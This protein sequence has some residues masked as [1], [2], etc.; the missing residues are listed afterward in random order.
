MRHAL[1]VFMTTLAAAGF[2]VALYVHL[3]TYAGTE[4][5]RAGWLF[6][7]HILF[8]PPFITLMYLLQKD[9]KIQ[10]ARF[11]PDN[12]GRQQNTDEDG[13]PNYKQKGR[14]ETSTIFPYGLAR[15]GT[16]LLKILAL[17]LLAQVVFFLF[18]FPRKPVSGGSEAG[19]Y[20]ARDKEGKYEVA[21]EEYH[22]LVNREVRG[23]SAIWL[24]VYPVCALGLW[25]FM[26]GKKAEAEDEAFPWPEAGGDS[27]SGHG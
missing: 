9:G 21:A 1:T 14:F 13:R 16:V 3:A 11:I 4:A 7:M 12:P 27:G 18:F 22:G 8:I 20:F 10:R 2:V 5:S 26:K 17:N 23:Y 19:G 24:V 15:W 6:F 25:S